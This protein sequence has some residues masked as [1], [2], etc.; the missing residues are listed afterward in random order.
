MPVHKHMRCHFRKKTRFISNGLIHNLHHPFR[1]PS[2]KKSRASTMQVKKHHSLFS[3]YSAVPYFT[4]RGDGGY[5]ATGVS[6]QTGHNSQLQ[7][8]IL[9]PGNLYSSVASPES[10][11]Q[12]SVLCEL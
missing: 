6:W 2:R 1:A 4:S 7:H 10:V 11:Q 3:V 5:L 9:T 8:R 12:A